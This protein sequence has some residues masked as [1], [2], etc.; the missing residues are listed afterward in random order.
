MVLGSTCHPHQT[1]DVIDTARHSGNLV[2]TCPRKCLYTADDRTLSLSHLNTYDYLK[3]DEECQQHPQ[4][5]LDKYWLGLP[6]VRYMVC[7]CVLI[8]HAGT[9]VTCSASTEN[10]TGCR[11]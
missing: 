9:G 4:T 1:A 7:A 8:T 5:V 3:T 10:T 11:A 2:A 6:T